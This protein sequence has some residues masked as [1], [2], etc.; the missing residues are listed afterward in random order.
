MEYT[1]RLPKVREG[2]GARVKEGDELVDVMKNFALGTAVS[3]DVFPA[4]ESIINEETQTYV[5]AQI[6]GCEDVEIVVS[7]T[8][9]YGE[10]Q[11]V[12]GSGYVLRVG[13]PIYVRGPGY[14]GS[15]EVW[16]IERG[17]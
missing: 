10:E 8:A 9:T 16:A 1:L 4:T 11:I 17:K 13:D 3:V 7:T 15:G 2:T 5:T 14:L 12:T 6:P